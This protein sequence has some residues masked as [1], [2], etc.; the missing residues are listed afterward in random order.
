[1]VD[2]ATSQNIWSFCKWMT[3]NRTY[4][5]PPLDQG[6][7]TS[8]AITH[9]QKCDTLRKHLFP[10][11][12]Q[13]ENEPEPNWN[14]HPDDLTYHSITKREVKDMIYTVAQLNA[15]G[16]S[17]LTGRAWRWAWEVL[18]EAMFNLVRLC[19]DSGYHP[20]IWRTSIAVTLQK[21]NRDYSKPQSYRL[22]QLLEVLGK[23]LE[24]LQAHR[25]SYYAA[26]Y[27][28]FPSTQYSRISGR[29][30]QDA[31]MTIT[32]DIEA[33][34]NHDHTVSMLAFNITGFFDT[35]PTPTYSTHYANPASCY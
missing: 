1:M 21:P 23:T 15:P 10:E 25:L 34:W 19:A 24:R 35:I 5:S 13:L 33:A 12:P 4:M 3:T 16:L 18:E 20:K 32:H 9:A 28:L 29:S 17:R 11:P 26:K 27:K 2:E 7:N 22:I 8:P 31:V 6:E 14:D 30:A